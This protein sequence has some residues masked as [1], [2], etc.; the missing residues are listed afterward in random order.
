MMTNSGHEETRFRGG[1]GGSWRYDNMQF[2]LV[3][4]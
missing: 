2:I 4:T 1:I 3:I